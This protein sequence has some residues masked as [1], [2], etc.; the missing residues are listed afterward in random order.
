MYFWEK[1]LIL[2]TFVLKLVNGT[3]VIT[4]VI[5]IKAFFS[6]DDFPPGNFPCPK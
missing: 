4:R 5:S 2:E 3:H 6:F 1:R